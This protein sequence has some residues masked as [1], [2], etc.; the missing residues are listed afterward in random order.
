MTFVIPQPDCTSLP[1]ANSEHVFPV[2]RIFCI[3][4]NYAEHTREMGGSPEKTPPVFF[5]KPADAIVQ[6][7]SAIDYPQA[8]RDLHHE[9]EL[10]LAL[11][12]GGTDIAP[13]DADACIYGY[14]V[15]ID[16]TRRDLQKAAKDAGAP[17]DVGKAFDNSA[18]CSAIVRAD[19]AGNPANADI[20]LKVNGETRQSSNTS[21]MIWS[22]GETVAA[23]SRLFELKAGDL[24]Y[25]GTPEGVA[26]VTSGDRI[27]AG[28]SNVGELTVAIR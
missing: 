7:G 27:E 11:K 17:W 10:V 18:P 9:V 21:K 24:I 5:T 26:A 8:T 3:G 13:D 12:S 16:F 23:L 25:T 14:A 2:R 19:A 28:V 1:V 15:G 22:I 20:W 6:S 4:R